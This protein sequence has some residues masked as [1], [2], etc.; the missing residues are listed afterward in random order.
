MEDG[1]SSPR[2]EVK[3][4]DVLMVGFGTG[5]VRSTHE[6]LIRHVENNVNVKIAKTVKE[7]LELHNNVNMYTFDLIIF[8]KLD[9]RDGTKLCESL[10]K[11][12]KAKSMIV[13]VTTSDKYE[14]KCSAWSKAGVNHC[15]VEPLTKEKLTTVFKTLKDGPYKKMVRVLIAQ[16]SYVAYPYKENLFREAG[17]LI[18]KALDA[19]QASMV[20]GLREKWPYSM[21]V[22]VAGGSQPEF[23]A[24]SKALGVNMVFFNRMPDS[25]IRDFVNMAKL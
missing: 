7:A 15:L 21:L 11:K 19:K 13:G 12:V 22:G 3:T 1:S 2:S 20:K 17:A 4:T 8:M 10:T 5:S 25:K 14:E 23:E 6:T 16:E 9:K 18:T 24:L